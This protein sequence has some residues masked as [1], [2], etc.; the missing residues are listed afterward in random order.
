MIAP[1]S[2]ALAAGMLFG[3]GLWI[4][5]MANPRKVLGFL[6][7]TGAW[8]ASLL[9]VLGGAVGVTLVAFRL[10]LKRSRPLFAQLFQLPQRSDIDAKLVIGSALFG[11]GW[12]IGGYCPGP[13]ITALASLSAEAVVFVIAMIAGGLAH[14][15]L[16]ERTADLP[17]PQETT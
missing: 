7:V 12:G 6:D 10:V 11:A 3:F 15:M 2:S 16:F 13:G 14:R 1:A 4:S 17:A 9:F 8:D 5:G